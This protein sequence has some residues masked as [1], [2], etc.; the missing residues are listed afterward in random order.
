[1]PGLRKTFGS[2]R[3]VLRKLVTGP[4]SRPRWA[5]PHVR[6]V[7]VH[8]SSLL[9]HLIRTSYRDVAERFNLTLQ[10]CPK[11]PS[12]CTRDWVEKDMKRGVSYHCLDMDEKAIGCVAFEKAGAQEG[13][14]ERLAVLPE[15]RQNG[16]GK[17]LVD[18]V[19]GLARTAGMCRIGIGIISEQQDLKQWYVKM[20]FVEQEIKTF[21][22]LPFRVSLLAYTL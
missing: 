16:L 22:H 12:N 18:H 17:K 14:L 2:V 20:G 6:N 13:Y 3:A 5:H 10:N 1:M 9:A 8:E 19:F 7:G 21:S 4:F 11:H 15:Y